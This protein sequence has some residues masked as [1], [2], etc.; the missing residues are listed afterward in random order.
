MLILVSRRKKRPSS[1][2]ASLRMTAAG[3]TS[4]SAVN[5]YSSTSK[6]TKVWVVIKSKDLERSTK[7]TIVHKH[8][9]KESS[10]PKKA[11]T[12]SIDIMMRSHLTMQHSW[13]KS[14]SNLNSTKTNGSKSWTRMVWIRW[15]ILKTLNYYNKSF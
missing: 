2:N 3:K 1:S 11:K 13:L 15:R 10:K 14:T 6:L 5:L 4:N 7:R 8:K 12:T 9:K